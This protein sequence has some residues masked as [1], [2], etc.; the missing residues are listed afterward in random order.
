MLPIVVCDVDACVE[1]EKLCH[2]PRVAATSRMEQARLPKHV[3]M[4]QPLM[5]MQTHAKIIGATIAV[6]WPP[7]RVLDD[8]EKQGGEDI[9][10]PRR[11]GEH[12]CC[13]PVA[14][15]HEHGGS[16]FEKE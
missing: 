6:D 3:L 1:C 15:L 9:N 13:A 16:V 12:D 14:A 2:T 5:R 8:L 7:I 10:L 4:I 11:S